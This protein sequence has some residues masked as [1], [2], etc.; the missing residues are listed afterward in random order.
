[1]PGAALHAGTRGRGPRL[2]RG[3]AHTLGMGLPVPG[4]GCPPA[5]WRPWVSAS[6]ANG[7]LTLPHRVTER[8]GYS[9]TEDILTKPG[10]QEQ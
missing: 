4:S 8:T 9:D 3:H 7:A 6:L 10:K 1:M 2:C 5:L